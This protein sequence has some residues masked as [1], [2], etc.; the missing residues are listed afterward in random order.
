MSASFVSVTV[1]CRGEESLVSC[2]QASLLAEGKKLSDLFEQNLLNSVSLAWVQMSTETNIRTE[3]ACEA[4]VDNSWGSAI[5]ATGNPD[6]Q[7]DY[8]KGQVRTS[9]GI[10]TVVTLWGKTNGNTSRPR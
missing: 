3:N 5:L 2:K 9:T 10:P 4:S 8:S 6:T 7:G 1:S